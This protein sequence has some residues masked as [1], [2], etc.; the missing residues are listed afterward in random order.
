[1][2]SGS[3]IQLLALILSA[4]SLSPVVYLTTADSPL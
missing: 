2:F 3:F 1:M 4:S